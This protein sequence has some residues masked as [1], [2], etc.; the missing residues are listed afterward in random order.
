MEMSVTDAIERQHGL[1]NRVSWARTLTLIGAV[2]CP[3]WL[4][5]RAFSAHGVFAALGALI[6]LGI[7]YQFGASPLFAVA[8]SILCFHVKIVGLWL[9]VTS[10]VIGAILFYADMKRDNLLRRLAG[11]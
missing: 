1:E 11:K 4:V 6:M 10:Y 3:F 5:Y 2:I 9:P 7:V 8:A